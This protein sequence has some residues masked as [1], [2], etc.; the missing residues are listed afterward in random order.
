[1]KNIRILSPCFACLVCVI[2]VIVASSWVSPGHCAAA[3][4]IK[5]KPKTA[6]K[7]AKHRARVVS[8]SAS[9]FRPTLK[10]IAATAPAKSIRLQNPSKEDGPMYPLMPEFKPAMGSILTAPR[11]TVAG[12][13]G[14]ADYI[15]PGISATM[16]TGRDTSIT[17]AF[18]LPGF[19]SPP[20][21]PYEKPQ[22]G[23]SPAAAAGMKVTRSF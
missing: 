8:R 5:S 14:N 12:E 20:P 16:P 17:G 1:M 13:P 10:D 11:G 9:S 23:N 6:A 19:A 22:T 7:A 4:T 3:R 21:R 18:S 15:A 2:C